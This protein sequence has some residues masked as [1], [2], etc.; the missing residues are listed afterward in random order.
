M[1]RAFTEPCARARSVCVYL[2]GCVCP[3]AS[4]QS[5][6]HT[7]LQSSS[8]KA[9]HIQQAANRGS[10]VP[11]L[12]RRTD[13]PPSA[14]L[15]ETQTLAEPRCKMQNPRGGR[16]RVLRVPERLLRERKREMIRK[17]WSTLLLVIMWNITIG[18]C[19]YRIMIMIIIISKCHTFFLFLGVTLLND[20]VFIL[21]NPPQIACKCFMS[22]GVL[23]RWWMSSVNKSLTNKYSHNN[24]IIGKCY[25]MQSLNNMAG[26]KSIFSIPIRGNKKV[27]SYIF[28]CKN[29]HFSDWAWWDLDNHTFILCCQRDLIW[30]VIVCIWKHKVYQLLAFRHRGLNLHDLPS[31]S[32]LRASSLKRCLT[33]WELWDWEERQMGAGLQ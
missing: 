11:R 19:S 14:V 29:I 27:I 23:T 25:L 20:F 21:A 17:K 10:E 12:Q 26:D 9:L 16:V 24:N 7:L 13:E 1:E 15:H 3:V 30:C 28:Y 6:E 4:S 5:S 18:H 22:C 31:S 8:G 32:S 33:Q 2:L